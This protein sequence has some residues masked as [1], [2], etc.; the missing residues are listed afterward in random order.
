MSTALTQ[1]NELVVSSGYI[2]RYGPT[3]DMEMSVQLK[4]GGIASNA[5]ALSNVKITRASDDTGKELTGAASRFGSDGPAWRAA[6]E[7]EWQ[8]LQPIRLKHP[9]KS[10]RMIRHLEGEVD[11]AIP[12]MSNG[13]RFTIEDFMARPGESIR[14]A[15]LD[16][17]GITLIYH[18]MESFIDFQRAHPKQYVDEQDLRTE[19]Q[20]F[21]GIYGSPDDPPRKSV[22]I[23]VNDPQRKLLGFSFEKAD[24]VA[25][26]AKQSSSS[27][28]F[29]CYRFD[30]VPPKDLRLVVLVAA[31]GV[32]RTERFALTN[33]WLPW[34]F[35]PGSPY[36]DPPELQATAEIS[37][38]RVSRATNSHL[39]VTFKGGPITNAIG[40]GAVVLQRAVDEDGKTIRLMEPTPAILTGNPLQVGFVPLNTSSAPKEVRKR[41]YLEKLALTSPLAWLEGEVEIFQPNQTNGGLMVFTNLLRL[42]GKKLVLSGEGARKTDLKFIGR[43]D[44]AQLR[45]ALTKSAA[46][47]EYIG[48]GSSDPT[49]S[50]RFDIWNPDGYLLNLGFRDK[51]KQPLQPNGTLR[52]GDTVVYHFWEAPDDDW[53][54][55]VYLAAPAAIQRHPFCA[56]NVP[57]KVREF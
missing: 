29:R 25:L 54:L 19:R 46:G 13:G 53:Q 7:D 31:P 56:E 5:F 45:N 40:I 2:G 10:A 14:D 44:F 20:C 6:R 1:T 22:A 52:F 27:P 15:R 24:G 41:I 33:V 35:S 17:Y 36:A 26:K 48:G 43:A 38:T 55:V 4:F 34:D 9:T 23:Q 50:L 47:Y 32:V 39:M 49:N 21:T 11:L 8:W 57:V 51:R 28:H 16:Q 12:T 30:V 42:A 3:H 18:T 37:V